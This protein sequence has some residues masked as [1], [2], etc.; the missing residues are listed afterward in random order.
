MNF[1]FF[2]ALK[3]ILAIKYPGQKNFKIGREEGVSLIDLSDHGKNM[4]I[5]LHLSG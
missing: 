1:H 2:S 3:L 4:K 5:I